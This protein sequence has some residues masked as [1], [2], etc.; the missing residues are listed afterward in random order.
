MQREVQED[1][2][3]TVS[4]AEWAD[5]VSGSLT[6]ERLNLDKKIEGVII[7][8]ASVGTWRGPR[9]GYQ[10]LGSNIAD[11]LYSQCDD[12]EWYGDSYNIQGRMIHHD[13]MNYALY[14]IAKDRSR[15]E[16]IADKIYSGEI[17]EVGFRKRTRSLYP[18]VADIYGWKIRRRKLRRGTRDLEIPQPS[19]MCCGILHSNR[20]H[21]LI[22]NSLSYAVPTARLPIH[23]AYAFPFLSASLYPVRKPLVYSAKLIAGCRPQSR[24]AF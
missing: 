12:A 20:G 15:P 18:Y 9:Q 6:D 17:D 24:T 4:D 19:G 3:Y 8:F 14:R 16:R 22:P 5:V 2:T 1:D 21:P 13:G 11:I 7:A 10:I 23:C